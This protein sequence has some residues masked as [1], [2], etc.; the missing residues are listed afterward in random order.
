MNDSI[1]T[2]IKKLLGI[3]EEYTHF[4]ED[5]IMHINSVFASLHQIGH[6]NKLFFITDDSALW[7][8]YIGD[9]YNL[10][11]VKSY[12]YMKVRMMFDPPQSS[13]SADAI[14]ENIEELEWRISLQG[15]LN[16]Q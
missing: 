11:M 9:E 14:K 2:S 5:I 1:L 12:I 4:D 10:Q 7:S 8:D 3:Q 13:I 6:S 15:E 16:K